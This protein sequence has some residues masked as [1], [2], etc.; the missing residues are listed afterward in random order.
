MIFEIAF[1]SIIL[2][3][4]NP[5]SKLH[6]F[7]SSAQLMAGLCPKDSLSTKPTTAAAAAASTSAAAAATTT[8]AVCAY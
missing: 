5:K 6:A 4:T 1:S 8:A 3:C 2:F 7:V